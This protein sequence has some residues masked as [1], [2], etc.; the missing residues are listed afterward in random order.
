MMD[1]P[2]AI[3]WLVVAAVLAAVALLVRRVDRYLPSRRARRVTQRW[4]VPPIELLAAAAAIG[5]ILGRL[6]E[7]RSAWSGLAYTLAV[8][9][10]AWTARAAAEDFVAGAILRMEG[11]IERGRRL[12]TTGVHG[13]VASLGFRSVEIEADDGSTVRVPWRTVARKPVRVGAG[14]SAVRSHSFT[15]TVPRTRPIERVLEEIP[16][17]AL[18]SPWA[19]TTRPPEVQLQGETDTS[20]ILEITAHALD[21]RFAPQIEADIREKLGIAPT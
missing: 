17:A 18:L 13:R 16:S 21:A 12:D 7:G 6:L 15:I 1:L 11:N 14:G 10:V 8:L 5:W 19:S 20:Y 3:R 2:G 9:A 4:I